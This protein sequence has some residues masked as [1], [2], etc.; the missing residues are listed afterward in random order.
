M[1]S[2]IPLFLACA[3]ALHYFSKPQW[4]NKCRFFSTK[5]K[6]IISKNGFEKNDPA[7]WA[8]FSPESLKIVANARRPLRGRNGILKNTLRW[9]SKKYTSKQPKT[10]KN[11]KNNQKTPAA[12]RP[13]G[14]SAPRPRDV[15]PYLTTLEGVL[16]MPWHLLLLSHPAEGIAPHQTNEQ[17][18][19]AGAAQHEERQKPAPACTH[20]TS[21]EGV[22]GEYIRFFPQF[23]I[24]GLF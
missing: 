3:T 23:S 22:R 20:V 18:M 2:E 21:F 1:R 12:P 9:D 17:L 14:P 5:K 13:L 10:T 15:Q 16:R 7:S 4:R 11:T 24:F 19:T 8:T 6:R